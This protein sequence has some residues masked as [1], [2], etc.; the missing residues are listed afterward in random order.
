MDNTIDTSFA[1]QSPDL[2]G[3]HFSNPEP[4]SSYAQHVP[5][6]SSVSHTLTPFTPTDRKNPFSIGAGSPY[7]H[8]NSTNAYS[9]NQG[10]YFPPQQPAIQP[11][12][13]HAQ[14]PIQPFNQPQE[15]YP[16][17]FKQNYTF[18]GAVKRESNGGDDFAPHDDDA[19][20][21]GARKKAKTEVK[22]EDEYIDNGGVAVDAPGGAVGGGTEVKT[23]FPV[24]RIKRI[25]Q[26]DEDVGK[27]AQV[28]PVAVCKS[29][30]YFQFAGVSA[31]MFD[32]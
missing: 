1:P 17:G 11:Y 29:S 31:D 13:Q 10:S 6:R 7:T 21:P 22:S 14:Q 9:G 26:S 15:Q 4:P 8:S 16:A 23:K 24:A 18:G 19:M 5:Y 25:M 27:V 2:S 30:P 12:G 32:V 20:A 28:T 3:D